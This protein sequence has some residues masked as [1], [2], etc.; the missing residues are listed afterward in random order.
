[1]YKL[2]CLSDLRLHYYTLSY[3]LKCTTD[4]PVFIGL[5]FY[6]FSSFNFKHSLQQ[7]FMVMLVGLFVMQYIHVKVQ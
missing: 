5:N 3:I 6:L 2:L 4:T 7:E 1:M